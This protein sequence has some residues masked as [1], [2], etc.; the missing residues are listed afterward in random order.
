MQL[1]ERIQAFIKVGEFINNHYGKRENAGEENLHLGLTELVKAAQIY[2]GW[3][4]EEFT[5]I[6]LRSI[7]S[8]LTR[9]SLESLAKIIP[10]ENKKP[11]V[12]ALICAGNIPMVCFHDVLCVLLTGNTVLIKM[13]SDDQVLLPFFLKLLTHYEPRFDDHVRLTDGK[14]TDFD[15]VIATGSNNSA[16]HFKHYF[17]KHPNIIRKNRSSV[18]VLTGKESRKELEELGKDIFYYYGL[19]CRNVSKLLVPKDYKFDPFFEA[20]FDFSYVI[21]NKKYANNYEY[22][23]TIYLMGKEDF[24]DNNFLILKPDNQ[25][26]API[27]V[28]YYQRYENEKEVEN[29]LLDNAK[30]IQ[31]VVGSDHIP[32]GNSQCP[33][34]TDFADGINTAEFLVYL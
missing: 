17:A 21:D 11:K 10:P 12:V 2:N 25:I 18:A 3:F 19:G 13:S 20:M 7:A 27:S 29:Y 14:I 34:I 16:D 22:N 6:A 30:E 28:V 8:M 15:A 24:L 5:G 26:H 33:V 9:E 32:F 23:R 31:C 1:N 4:T